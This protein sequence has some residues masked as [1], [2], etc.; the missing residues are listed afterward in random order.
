[1]SG[2][3]ALAFSCL[4]L[5]PTAHTRTPNAVIP[6][7]AQ[8]RLWHHK[9]KDMISWM[10]DQCPSCHKSNYEG[11]EYEWDD[12]GRAQDKF[13]LLIPRHGAK[14]RRGLRGTSGAFQ[15]CPSS[16]SS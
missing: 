14:Q 10:R 3:Q 4:P 15:P 8:P 2:F 11:G 6:D 16:L 12:D 9:H 1:M 5:R 7:I 13:K